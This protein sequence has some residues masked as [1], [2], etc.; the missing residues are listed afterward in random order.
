MGETMEIYGK[1]TRDSAIKREKAKLTK[2]FK[3]LPIDKQGALAGLIQETAFMRVILGEL[4]EIITRE[5]PVDDFAQ[6]R[7]KFVRQHPAVKT[8]NTL[9]SRYM[10]ACKQLVDALPMP[11]STEKDELME[12]VKR[13]TR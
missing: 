12:F 8:Y 13:K 6:G 10:T 2:L 5:G 1:T 4:Q 9:I 7:Q 3:N 11:L